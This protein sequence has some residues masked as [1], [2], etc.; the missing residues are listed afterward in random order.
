MHADFRI[1]NLASEDTL[2]ALG[3]GTG[4]TLPKAIT[5]VLVRLLQ[6]LE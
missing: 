1:G 6:S 4:R 2:F 5:I 3:P